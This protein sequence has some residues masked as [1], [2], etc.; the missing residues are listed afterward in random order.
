MEK[1]QKIYISQILLNQTVKIAFPI[2]IGTS[3]EIISFSNVAI[4]IF[5]VTI[6]QL[7]ISK[8]IKT[9]NKKIDSFNLL[10]YTKKIEELGEQGKSI[11]RSY[12]IAFL[13]GINSS[14]LSTLITII[15]IMAFNTSFNL[16]ALTTVF[17]IC[18]IVVAI[19]FQKIYKNKYAKKYIILCSV[20][21][22]ISVLGLVFNINKTT[23]IIYNFFNATCFAMLN[24]IKNTQRYNCAKIGEIEKN[25]IEHQSIF[26][27]TLACGRIIG[28]FMLLL[29]GL[30]NNIIYFKI[31][32]IIAIIMLIPNSLYLYQMEKQ[33]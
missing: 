15:I 6:I 16:G 1:I 23:V 11:K 13:E 12:K 32:L 21:P 8:F 3:I 7:I 24:N 4:I 25:Q 18:T 14:L 17:S 22:L 19:I 30:L 2:I 33:K 9:I 5:I 31:L 20:L 29:V 28:Y 26:E 10:K 27:I